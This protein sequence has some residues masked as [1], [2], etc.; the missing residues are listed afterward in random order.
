VALPISTVTQSCRAAIV[1]AGIIFWAGFVPLRADEGRLFPKGQKLT[2]V[3]AVDMRKLNAPERVMISTLQGIL[4]KSSSRQ[5]FM[6][7]PS[8][9]WM[10]FL[11]ERY[12]MRVT[13]V[14]DPWELLAQFA[15]NID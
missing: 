12:G 13:T 2:S 8:P 9:P 6:D 3:V 10:S 5:I 15:T 7:E 11:T 1:L 14:P 4:A